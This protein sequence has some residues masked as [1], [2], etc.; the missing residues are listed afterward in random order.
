VYLAPEFFLQD[1]THDNKV[2]IWALGI[3]MFELTNGR[4]PF[5][6]NNV[7]D[8]QNA[9]LHDRIKFENGISIIL[10]DIITKCLNKNPKR[11][12]SVGDLLKNE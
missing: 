9:I 1:I 7:V 10:R 12:P 11:R 3:I 2:D 5:Q 4:V 6:R 8:T